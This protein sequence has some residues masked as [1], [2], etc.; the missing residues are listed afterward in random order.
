VALPCCRQ[1]LPL[2]R[3]DLSSERDKYLDGVA[4]MTAM[5]QRLKA[6]QDQ[7]AAMQPR[8]QERQAEAS[9]LMSLIQDE[10]AEAEAALVAIVPEEEQV[11]A[12]G[13]G[14][15]GLG[16]G[17][18][19]GSSGDGA[20]CFQMDQASCCVLCALCLTQASLAASRKQA[21]VAECEAD[22]GIVMPPLLKALKEL[23]AIDKAAIAE[24][25]VM[26][27]PPE[28]VKL[29]M[30]AICIMLGAIPLVVSAG[31]IKDEEVLKKVRAG[32]ITA[33]CCAVLCCAVSLLVTLPLCSES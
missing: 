10:K 29:V 22:L 33:L 31:K 4:K 14:L 8:L 28:G 32:L 17:L 6:L 26:K 5:T 25:K 9:Q 13:L 30:R 20:L 11:G 15:L 7:V 27:S 12:L 24:L 21:L 19:G 3:I 23:R 2:K 18:G 1:T 16:L